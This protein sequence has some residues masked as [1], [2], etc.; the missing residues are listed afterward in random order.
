MA[1]IVLNKDFNPFLICNCYTCH[2][3]KAFRPSLFSSLSITSNAHRHP[4]QTIHKYNPITHTRTT[5]KMPSL[6][7][8]AALAAVLATSVS[9]SSITFQN[10]GTANICYMVELTTGTF[11]TTTTCGLGN[12]IAVNAGQTNTIDLDPTFNGALTAWIGSTRGARYEVNFAA[13]PGST[14]YDADY[15]LGMSDGTLGPSDNRKLSNGNPSQTGEP[16]CLAKANAAWPSTTNQ[17]ALLAYPDYLQ[18]GANGQLSYV[19]C[20]TNAPQEVIDFFQVTADF[21]A[22]IDAG[23]VA[24]VTPSAADALAVSMANAQSLQVGTQDMTIVAH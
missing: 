17:A 14:W 16:D 9:S 19:Y 11:D 2:R 10:A 4:S 24:G 12:G 15:Q 18:Q 23:S 7:T 5:R 6:H 13:T 22:Y 8:L 21:D 20:D 3:I 1:R